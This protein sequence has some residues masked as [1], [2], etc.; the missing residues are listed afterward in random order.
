MSLL[1]S[2]AADVAKFDPQP[3]LVDRRGR[4][5]NSQRAS[6]HAGVPVGAVVRPSGPNRLDKSA[7]SAS[8]GQKMSQKL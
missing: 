2:I 5:G 6:A 4:D 3:I 7:I 8:H 1:D